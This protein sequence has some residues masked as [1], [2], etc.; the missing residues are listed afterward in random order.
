MFTRPVQNFSKSIFCWLNQSKISL[1]TLCWQ[2]QFQISPNQN[3]VDMASPKF[4]QNDVLLT[5]PVQNF[6]KSKFF[7]QDQSKNLPNHYFIDKTSPKFHQ[8]NQPKIYQINFILTRPVQ[9]FN[10]KTSQKFTKSTLCGQEQSKISPNQH[11]D[12][13]IGQNFH[14]NYHF[15]D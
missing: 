15:V 6:T 8:Q 12:E 13:N 9:N 11:F 5:G 3:F 7:W 14:Q 2:D 10:N 4:H 1:V